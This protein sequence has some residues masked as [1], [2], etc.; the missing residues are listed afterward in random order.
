M[1]D[2]MV[3]GYMPACTKHSTDEREETVS[4]QIF[5]FFQLDLLFILRFCPQNA[6]IIHFHSHLNFKMSFICHNF[7]KQQIELYQI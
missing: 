6:K 4:K 2:I 7:K 5:Y 1:G 3:H